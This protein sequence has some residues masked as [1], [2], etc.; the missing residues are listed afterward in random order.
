MSA[1]DLLLELSNLG[2]ELRAVDAHLE[3]EGPEEAVTQEL[4]DKLRRHK[5]ELIGLLA[6][7]CRPEQIVPLDPST[8][9]LRA[10]GWKPKERSKTIWQSREN[11]FWYSQETALQLSKNGGAA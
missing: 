7:D 2:V 8:H 11:G 5:V 10:S 4:L 6:G 3:Y 9:G 1:K